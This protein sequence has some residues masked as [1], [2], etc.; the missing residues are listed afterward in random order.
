MFGLTTKRRCQA[1]VDEV[2][3][4]LDESIKEADGLGNTVNRL[5]KERDAALKAAQASDKAYAT[6]QDS[7]KAALQNLEAA[8]NELPTP[9]RLTVV[10][11]AKG[12]WRAELREGRNPSP[13]LVSAVQ[14][15]MAD[16]AELEGLIKRFVL[17]TGKVT[18]TDSTA[19]KKAGK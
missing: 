18:R 3:R 8:R 16:P 6:S 5:E 9:M 17:V 7:L 12:L 13:L 15:G 19:R 1:R 14:A 10:C 4:K 2:R 11:G